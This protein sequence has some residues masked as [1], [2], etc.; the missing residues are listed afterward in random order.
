MASIRKRTLPSGRVAWLV[1]YADAAGKRRAKQ[2]ATKREADAWSVQARSEVAAGT[3][4]HDRDSITVEKAG[5]LWITRCE[6]EGLER[7]TIRGY[8]QH[9]D[10]HIVPRIG[11]TKLS[12]LT[13]PA[14]AAFRDQL[15]ADGRSAAMVKRVLGSLSAL[16]AEAQRKGL[17]AANHVK[18]GG[19][20]KRGKR[21][22]SH[23]EMPTRDELR[24]MLAA[25]SDKTRPLIMVA[26]LCGLRGSELRGL[27]WT[28]ID[29]K[30]GV[31]KVRRRVDRYNV[32]G[33][34]KSAAGN[35]DIPLSPALVKVLK[36]WKLACPK[37]DMG[38]VFPTG[39]GGVESHGNLLSRVFWPLQ[40]TAGITALREAKDEAGETVK[41]PDAKYSLH[42]LRHAAAALWIEQGIN[43]KRIQYL[44]GHSSIQQT[45]DVYGYLLEA[46]DDDA[47]AMDEIASRLLS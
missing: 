23:I 20:T 31:L 1:D 41:V 36:E 16:V 30:A 39:A 8:R 10:L 21:D 14:V 33:P 45:F 6:A 32:S 46:R 29:L 42:A 9:L 25:T 2:F 43:A 28:D 15:T 35:R 47:G 3:H 4:T 17:V 27:L 7:T 38:L 13:A 37:G 44:M 26:L 12:R 11:A 40:L 19:R 24:A 5:D 22:Q 34:P 18:A